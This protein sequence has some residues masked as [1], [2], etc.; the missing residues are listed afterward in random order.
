ML[1]SD[2][3]DMLRKGANRRCIHVCVCARVHM[4]HCMWFEVD[5]T[6]ISSW[7]NSVAESVAVVDQTPEQMT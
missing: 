3:E 7:R 4:Q 5:G 2:Y 6:S 1:Q